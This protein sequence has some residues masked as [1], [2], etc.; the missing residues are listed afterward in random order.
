MKLIS[1]E[2]QEV[3]SNVKTSKYR[4]KRRNNVLEVSSIS[5]SKKNIFKKRREVSIESIDFNLILFI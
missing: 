1:H 3:Y 2:T 5:F 4:L